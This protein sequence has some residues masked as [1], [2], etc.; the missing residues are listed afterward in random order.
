[1]NNL[2]KD[3]WKSKTVW[4]GLIASAWPLVQLG[5]QVFGVSDALPSQGDLADDIMSGVTLVSAGLAVYGRV[6]ASAPIAKAS[7]P[8][9]AS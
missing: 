2:P 9:V 8:K 3:W 1:M 6:T 5:A 4:A 7:T